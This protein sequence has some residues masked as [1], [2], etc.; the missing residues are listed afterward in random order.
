MTSDRQTGLGADAG[1]IIDE[2]NFEEN[3]YIGNKL[4]IRRNNRGMYVTN[5]VHVQVESSEDVIVRTLAY[6]RPSWFWH[7]ACPFTDC[8]ACRL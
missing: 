7:R 4:Q 1:G 6:L 8:A 2:E 3:K 5:T